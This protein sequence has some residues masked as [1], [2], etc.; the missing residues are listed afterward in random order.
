MKPY[1]KAGLTYRTKHPTKADFD[2]QKC[3]KE[4]MIYFGAEVIDPCVPGP[5]VV[6]PFSAVNTTAILTTDQ[7]ET[8]LITSTSPS[9]VSMTLPSAITLGVALGAQKGFWFDFTVDNTAGVSMVTIV[10]GPGDNAINPVIT[11]EGT[12]TIAAGTVAAFKVYFSSAIAA[13]L[14]R[15]I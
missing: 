5:P 14:I 12:L 8:Q 9:A 2:L 13:V 7:M 4:T 1:I 6:K 3:I 10:S 11:G 15:L